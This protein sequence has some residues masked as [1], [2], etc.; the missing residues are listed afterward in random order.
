MTE[1]KIISY[2]YLLRRALKLSI[3]AAIVLVILFFLPGIIRQ[4]LYGF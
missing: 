2:P 1:E 4:V 3:E